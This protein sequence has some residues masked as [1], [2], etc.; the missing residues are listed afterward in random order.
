MELD[1]LICKLT[2]ERAKLDAVIASLEQLRK[3]VTETGKQL[4]KKRGRKFM[5][6]QGR[7]EVSERMKKYWASR[8]DNHA[9]GGSAP[10]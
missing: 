8:R 7:K 4:G 1:T 2:D 5:D 3:A 10:A 6:E 9:G